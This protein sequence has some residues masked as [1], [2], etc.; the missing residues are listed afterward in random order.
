MNVSKVS[1]PLSI[2]G[3]K[4]TYPSDAAVHSNKFSG[5]YTTNNSKDNRWLDLQYNH[6]N[7]AR[8]IMAD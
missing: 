5:G 2:L 1:T 4:S 7:S 6:G 3:G 8:K